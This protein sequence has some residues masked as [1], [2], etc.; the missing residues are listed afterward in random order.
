MVWLYIFSGVVLAAAF[1]IY[2]HLRFKLAVTVDVID[3]KATVCVTF[4]R[5]K[6]VCFDL[7]FEKG[8]IVLYNKK[9]VPVYYPVIGGKKNAD[10]EIYFPIF[11]KLHF[12]SLCMTTAVGVTGNA[13][14]TALSLSAARLAYDI[15]F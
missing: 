12:K 7:A 10:N 3:L 6:T 1:C 11:D 14:A 13:A 2:F 5:L 8:F 9:G 4:F 15:V